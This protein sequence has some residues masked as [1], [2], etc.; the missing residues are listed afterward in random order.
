VP[1]RNIQIIKQGIK[2]TAPKL[3]VPELR[4]ETHKAFMSLKT[5]MIAEFLNHP[6]TQEI[7]AGPSAPNLSGT[8]DGR[9]NLFAFIGFEENSEPIAPI[10]ELLQASNIVTDKV[11]V[12]GIVSTIY[13]PTADEIFAVTPMP[14]A[15]GRSWAHGIESGISGLGW[16]IHQRGLGRSGG[17]I[18]TAQQSGRSGRFKNVQYISALINKYTKLLRDI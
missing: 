11:T 4:R 1:D 12:R 3:F 16:Y 6:I 2:R 9:G 13:I 5:Q 10:L 14:W 15:N 17:G 7:M 8:L 18:Q